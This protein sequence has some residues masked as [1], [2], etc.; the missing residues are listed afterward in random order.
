M[1]GEISAFGKNSLKQINKSNS[2]HYFC[3][4]VE[5][6]FLKILEDDKSLSA[7]IACIKT[8]LKVLDKTKC[9]NSSLI[10]F[11]YQHF[12]FF[13]VE[14]VQELHTTIQSAVKMMRYTEQP[15]TV[16]A[17]V[18]GSELFS[19]FIT[20]AKFDDKVCEIISNPIV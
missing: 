13:K 10:L 20:L 2:N 8:L 9:E 14:T 16:T 4:A 15:I 11:L 18:S 5:K 3:L 17:V 1:P 7:G 6:Y 19:R 12:F